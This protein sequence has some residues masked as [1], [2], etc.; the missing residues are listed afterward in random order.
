MRQYYPVLMESLQV[1]IVVLAAPLLVGW[2]RTLKCWTQGRSS[3]GL[4]QP[5][6]D[7]KK[8]LV[9]DVVLAENASWIFTAT[10]YI[11]FGATLMAG[12]IIPTC[13]LPLR[14]TS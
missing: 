7:I 1:V 12:A 4:L 3:A 11:V 8:L 10:P 5:M 14:P 13:R 6:R 2:I 9:K